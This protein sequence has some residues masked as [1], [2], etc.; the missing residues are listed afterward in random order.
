LYELE[1]E[2]T[3]S[4]FARFLYSKLND[5]ETSEMILQYGLNQF[6]Y[7]K[8]ADYWLSMLGTI[9]R[10]QEKWS[11]AEELYNY[12]IVNQLDIYE[13][14]IGLGWV[15]YFREDDVESAIDMFMRSIEIQPESGDGYFAVAN[16]LKNEER[17]EESLYWYR[18]AI[19]INPEM[20]QWQ[21]KYADALR[22]SGD[23]LASV[24]V[25]KTIIRKYPDNAVPYSELAWAY[26][27]S[28]QPEKAVELIEKAMLIGSNIDKVSIY[29]RASL[30]FES[31]G[32][33]NIALEHI[34]LALLI[35]PENETAVDIKNRLDKK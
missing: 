21:I 17:Y 8:F 23:R 15:M 35:D 28:D 31:L 6:P 4:R 9:L 2:Y 16:V 34:Q 7:S 13:A 33:F 5:F 27:L 26:Y 11:E 14:Y 24:E 32:D 29:I 30:I 19:E 1:P 25:Y 10:I 18:K 3:T 20:W 22:T 12:M